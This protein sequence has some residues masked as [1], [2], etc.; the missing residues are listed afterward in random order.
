MTQALDKTSGLRWMAGVCF[1]IAPL[2]VLAVLAGGCI[3]RSPGEVR[4]ARAL[5]VL[6]RS[7]APEA[8]ELQQQEY[9]DIDELRI[10]LDETE[11]ED[12]SKF[13]DRFST[14]I[15]HLAAIRDKRSH[16]QAQIRDTTWKTPLV[17]AIQLD[18]LT[19]FQEEI[20]RDDAWME[21]ARNV[22]TRADLGR[23]R[24]FP[25]VPVLRRQLELF[26]GESHDNVPLFS[27]IQTLRAEYGFSPGEISH[28]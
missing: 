16:L 27:Q 2:T 21:L 12:F 24:D 22:R 1:R 7:M 25:E 28:Q 9:V 4:E 11:N 15:D 23:Q 10:I 5:A 17:R 20:S 18:V 6:L 3:Y 26:S 8:A 19:V 13:R 14:S